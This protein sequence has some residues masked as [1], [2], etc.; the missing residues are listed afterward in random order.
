MG[1][2]EKKGSSVKWLELDLYNILTKEQSL[3][4]QKT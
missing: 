2:T 4:F 1:F 3:G